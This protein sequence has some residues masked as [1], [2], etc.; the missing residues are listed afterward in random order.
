MNLIVN[1]NTLYEAKK[2]DLCKNFFQIEVKPSQAISFCYNM[3]K[4]NFIVPGL[5]LSGY[6]YKSHHIHIIISCYCLSNS[7][8]MAK[9]TFIL[10][11]VF[12]SI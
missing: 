1:T 2:T 9:L 10:A 6:T 5:L 3:Y 7:L 11:P 8:Y 12:C 4:T